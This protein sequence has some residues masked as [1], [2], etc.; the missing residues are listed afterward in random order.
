[1]SDSTYD[2]RLCGACCSGPQAVPGYVRLYDIDLER[3]RRTALPI[4]R[5]EDQWSDWSE[6]IF[7]LGTKIDGAG[8]RVCI[9]FEGKVGDSCGCGIYEQRPNICRK[10]EPGSVPCREARVAAGLPL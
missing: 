9:A 7:R 1:M 10:V 4:L 5:S 2:C 8:R 6:E 3:L